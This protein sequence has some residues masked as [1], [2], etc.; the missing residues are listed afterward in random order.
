[1]YG[2][3]VIKVTFRDICSVLWQVIICYIIVIIKK[4]DPFRS[5]NVALLLP[6]AG[7][8]FWRWF[9]TEI[10]LNRIFE[11]NLICW[12]FL[13]PFQLVICFTFRD[14]VFSRIVWIRMFIIYSIFSGKVVNLTTLLNSSLLSVLM[15]FDF[16]PNF[17][18]TKAMNSLSFW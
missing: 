16:S 4:N 6:F 2:S 1:M 17:L 15:L 7:N 18:L 5:S 9:A 8:R 10:S 11:I 14:A 12:A 3:L 13:R